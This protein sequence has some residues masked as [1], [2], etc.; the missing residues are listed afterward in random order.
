M[1]ELG[2]LRRIS[3]I[4]KKNNLDFVPRQTLIANI[5]NKKH[6]ISL[7]C[8]ENWQV[9]VVLLDEDN[10]II[11]KILEL[12]GDR[13]SITKLQDSL[14]VFTDQEAYVF[15][16]NNLSKTPLK[17]SLGNVD[18]Q[19]IC[20]NENSIFAYS[21]K[22]D[23]IIKYDKKLNVV[24]EYKNQWS[25]ENSKISLNLACNQETFFSVP[26]LPTTEEHYQIMKGIMQQC[27]GY[28]ISQ[29]N[30]L[31]KS[32]GFNQEENTI[33]IA[34]YNLIWIIKDGREYSYLHFKGKGITTAL[35]DNNFKKLVINFGGTKGNHLIGSIIELSNDQ[36]R[37]MATPITNISQ[38]EALISTLLNS[39]NNEEEHFNKSRI[40]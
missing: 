1:N 17:K 18:I 37:K 14:Y 24:E 16:I 38:V 32:C 11:Y 2:I 7:I 23:K 40:Q 25:K 39:K 31:I 9:K 35:Y 27:F 26:I 29:A 4:I 30:D 5:N 20:A 12:S 36:I 10:K 19:G 15:D 33:Y 13:A 6:Y 28:R 8:D 3:N 34:M 22:K 21:I